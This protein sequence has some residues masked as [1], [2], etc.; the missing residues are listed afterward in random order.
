[1]GGHAMEAFR[2]SFKAI[3]CLI[4]NMIKKEKEIETFCPASKE[5]WRQWLEAHHRSSQAVWL[6]QYKKKAGKATIT[7][8]EAVDEALCFGW[9]DSIRKSVDS[10]TFIQFF[11]PRKPN[12]SVWSAIN[13]EKVERLI[14]EGL[15]TPLGH[16]SIERAK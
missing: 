2:P 14:T 8:S 15:M 7:W 5:E 3:W 4:L 9:I 1:M 16:A 13:K 10:E 11:G 12:N 6:V